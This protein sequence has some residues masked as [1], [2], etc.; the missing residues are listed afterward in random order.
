[1]ILE[2][3]F[4]ITSAS[5]P[6]ITLQTESAL[7]FFQNF[8]VKNL[9]Q[10]ARDLGLYAEVNLGRDLKGRFA[11]FTTPKHLL[12]ARSNG[13]TWN[14]KG[15]VRLNISEFPTC[16]VEYDGEQCPDAFYGTCFERLFTPGSQTP[17]T[18]SAEAQQVLGL[19]LE[20]IYLGLGNSFFSLYN[21]A[22][23]PIIEQVNTTGT[24]AVDTQEWVDYYGQQMSG[25]CGGL[26]T[27]LDAL[28]E[29]DLYN[30][31]YNLVI[32]TG[33]SGIDIATDKYVG[34]ITELF[35]ALVDAASPEL[36][37]AINRGVNVD[38]RMLKPVIL[39]T[40][41]EFNAYKKY[42]KDMAPTNEL[43]YRYLIEMSDGT[44]RISKNVME[45]EGLPVITWEANTEFDAITG[46]KSHRAAIVTPGS[47]GVLSNVEDVS[48][49]L[50]SGAGLVV[51]QST[52]L[53]D[54]GKVF[55]STT[56]R[57]GA[58]IADPKMCVM[59]SH[60]LRPVPA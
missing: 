41:A 29:D 12:G 39:V 27:Q 26:V 43:A 31:Y 7:R 34:D 52:S 18:D 30:Q 14:P 35:E 17:L 60:I 33:A 5:G 23:H 37:I 44:T 47:W 20:R 55:M 56:F 42:I 36:K 16:P 15:G 57:W 22:N 25:D 13:C 10:D 6:Q 38:G 32:S 40:T 54:K 48:N 45:W 3:G 46:V 8:A 53:E 1:M 9:D 4:S 59:A 50:F 51:Q 11:S 49:R 28:K 58:A 21:F 19:M 2:G 24:Y